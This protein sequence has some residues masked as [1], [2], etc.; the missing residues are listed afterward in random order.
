MVLEEGLTGREFSCPLWVK[1][2]HQVNKLA[3]S[4]T[5]QNLQKKIQTGLLV[6]VLNTPYRP[7]G[8]L[9]N[10]EAGASWRHQMG[11]LIHEPDAKPPFSLPISV[12][13]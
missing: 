9:S 2:R 3:H 6:F 11:Q 1:R 4:F 12:D 8:R 10:G 7:R 13:L 5:V